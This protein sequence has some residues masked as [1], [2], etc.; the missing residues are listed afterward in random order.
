VPALA[1]RHAGSST[2]RCGPT[3]PKSRRWARLPRP[4]FPAPTR[5]R[6]C[7]LAKRFPES[8]FPRVLI[9][10]PRDPV[11]CDFPQLP[12]SHRNPRFSIPTAST[13]ALSRGAIGLATATR[14]LLS[15]L[16][17]HPGCFQSFGAD[18][19]LEHILAN[20]LSGDPTHRLDVAKVFV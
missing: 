5:A 17:R 11:S 4:P 10:M 12:D 19:P 13:Q 18:P 3:F 14:P 9:P 6:F 8:A 2:R 7:H 16:D 15:P 20:E 1:T